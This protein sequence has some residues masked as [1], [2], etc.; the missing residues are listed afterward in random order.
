MAR[1]LFIAVG[2]DG[3]RVTSPD[4]QTWGEP[5]LGKEGETYRAVVC[6]KG[7]AIAV[8]GYGGNN[9]LSVTAD[10]VTW[11]L[12]QQDAQYSRYARGVTFGDQEFIALGGDPVSVGAAKPFILTTRNGDKWN[13]PIDIG[14]K[15]MLRRMAYG[16][17]KYVAV[18]DRGRRAV[19][20]DARTWTDVADVKPID[21]LIDVAYGNGAFVGVGLH[22][23]RTATQDGLK[24]VRP[25]RGEEGEHLNAVVWA[26]DHFVAVGAG[27]TYFSND[28]LKWERH[29]NRDAPNSVAYGDGVFVGPR[30]KG[31]LCY[32]TDG[33]EWKEVYQSKIHLEAVAFGSVGT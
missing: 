17:E 4:G 22:G 16:G 24:W 6:G 29:V 19:S 8:G 31:R 5:Q 25:Q 28:A 14:G 13:G 12:Q 10:G 21:T 2:H 33:I 23:L 9:I 26:K 3:T 15:F 7:L 20:K 1:N 11:K 27:V 18:G 32:S 30:W